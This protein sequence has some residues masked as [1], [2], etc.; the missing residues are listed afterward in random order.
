[1]LEQG[2][3]NPGV[4]LG[5]A[6]FSVGETVMK[7]AEAKGI[8]IPDEMLIAAAM[9]SLIMLSD[10]AGEAGFFEASE[11]DFANG[12]GVALLKF[13]QT[14][15]DKVDWQ[16]LQTAIEQADPQAVEAAKTMYN[17]QPAQA[18]QQQGVPAQQQAPPAGAQPGG[19]IGGGMA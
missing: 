19:I 3:D 13:M 2:K 18:G 7:H 8:E 4:A 6:V 9:D 16:S 14:H 1:M 17:A 11:E 10:L 15:P 12:Y 5:E